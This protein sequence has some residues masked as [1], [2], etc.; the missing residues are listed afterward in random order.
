MYTIVQAPNE[1]L[2]TSATDV[3]FFDD[4]LKKIVSEMIETMLAQKDPEGVGLAANQV[5]LPWKIFVARFGTKKTDEV[6]VFIN[7]QILSHSEELQP[8]KTT[9]KS[10]LEGCLSKPDYYGVVKRWTNL[11]LKYQTETGETKEETFE[12]FAATVI[13]HEMDHLDGKLFIE[14][15][16]EQQGK[17]Y[18]ITKNK[19]EEE[20]DEVEI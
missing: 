9:K 7:P 5:N 6:R 3:Y 4:K 20:W 2:R 18:K 11:K 15:I 14:R 13:Q 1:I 10:P 19:S 12:G 17:L 16:L 8:N